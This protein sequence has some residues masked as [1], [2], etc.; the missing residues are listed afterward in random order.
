MAQRNFFHLDTVVSPEENPPVL[1]ALPWR[2]S[3]E[4]V[5]PPGDLVKLSQLGL[6]IFLALLL[7]LSVVGQSGAGRRAPVTQP[8]VQLAKLTSNTVYGYYTG[9]AVAISGNVIVVGSQYGQQ[10]SVYVS[11]NGDWKDAVESATLLASDE[12][13]CGLFGTSVSISG[14]TIVVG[15]PQTFCY[16]AQPGAAY[17]F[18]EPSGGWSG[19]LTETAKLQA[20]DALGGD[21]VGTSVAIDGDTAVVGAPAT[22][23]NTSVNGAAYVFVRPPGGWSSTTQTA[24]LT[25]S[26]AVAGDLFG[27]SVSISGGAVAVGSPYLHSNNNH[28]GAAYVFVEPASGWINATQNAELIASDP[29]AYGSMGISVGISGRT[30][31]AGAYA[32]VG[33]NIA[34][35]AAYVFVEPTGGW[36]DTNQVAKLTAA[37]GHFDDLFG[38][39]VAIDGNLIVAGSIYFSGSSHRKTSA[40]SREG[41]A[42]LFQKPAGGWINMT[43]TFQLNGADARYDTKFGTAVAVGGNVVA[44]GMPNGN[45]NPGAGYVFSPFTPQ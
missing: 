43:Q 22:Y 41:A 40:F 2:A 10:A 36:Q 31:V 6:S 14:S 4:T 3:A 16:P 25:A 34:Q 26:D 9:P 35:G 42:Y 7:S 8:W 44:V 45:R 38:T 32:D 5:T 37:D 33:S 17:V 11:P 13:S 12:M 15:D 21:G 1:C 19:V 24:E 18:V 28:E 27:N 29:L 30:V 23:A 39:S 20:S